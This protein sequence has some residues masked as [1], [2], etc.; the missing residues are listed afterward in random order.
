ML[1]RYRR[2]RVVYSSTVDVC[3]DELMRREEMR[4]KHAGVLRSWGRW[5]M[6][7]TIKGDGG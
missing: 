1:I 7:M 2:V 6:M 4:V 5:K 3:F